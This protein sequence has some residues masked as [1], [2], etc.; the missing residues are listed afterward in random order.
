MSSKLIW[1][2]ELPIESNLT[3]QEQE[4]FFC[5]CALHLGDPDQMPTHTVVE[6]L[7]AVQNRSGAFNEFFKQYF[8]KRKPNPFSFIHYMI[9]YETEK[10]RTQSSA[11]K[12][13]STHT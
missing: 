1:A 8:P 3:P 11:R 2:D 12:P 4:D 13:G 7:D 6:R 9:W 5:A 10:H